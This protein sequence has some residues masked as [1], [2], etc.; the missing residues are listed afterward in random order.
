LG[1]FSGFGSVR[2]SGESHPVAEEFEG[3]RPAL[4][5]KSP[6]ER[7]PS[8]SWVELETVISQASVVPG[9]DE[10]RERNPLDPREV[11]SVEDRQFFTP[12]V[13]NHQLATP[14]Q[15]VGSVFDG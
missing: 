11:V 8:G 9:K 3:T 2:F 14:N 4:V 1:P 6:L 10:L 7:I 13:E 5:E 12:T 15:K